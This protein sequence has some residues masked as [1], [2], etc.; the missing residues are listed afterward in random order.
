[1][2]AQEFNINIKGYWRDKDKKSIPEHS[3]VYFV[4][5]AKYDADKVKFFK[6]IY[7]GESENVRNRIINHKKYSEWLQFVDQDNELC[8]STGYVQSIDRERV[9]ASYIFKH[10]PPINKKYVDSFPFDKTTVISTGKTALLNTN[11]TVNSSF[12]IH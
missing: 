11:F 8:F 2:V 4:Y 5:V 12:L 3:G 1:M 9:E 7:I 6:L 10:K